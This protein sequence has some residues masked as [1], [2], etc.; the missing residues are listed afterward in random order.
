MNAVN[1]ALSFV[2]AIVLEWLNQG[3]KEQRFDTLV[4][5]ADVSGFTA[6]SEK[7]SKI[8]D[9]GAEILTSILNNYFN[10]M[11]SRID[12]GGGFVGKFGG[13]AMTIFFPKNG[14]SEKEVA[15]RAIKTCLDL[16]SMMN[17]FQ[18]IETKAGTFSLGMKIGISDGSVLFRIVGDDEY[19]KE[20]LFTGTP[21]DDA[22]GAEHQGKSGEVII[23]KQL[24]KFYNGKITPR[25]D[26]FVKL[27]PNPTESGQINTES[28]SQTPFSDRT[29][30]EIESLIAIAKPFLDR[31]IFRRLSLGLDS[32]GEIRRVSVLFM[33]FTGFDYDNDLEVGDK[34]D[35]M[36]NWV[37]SVSSK[38]SGSINKVDMGD[39]GSK[40]IITFGAPTAH[41]FDIQ[42]AVYCGLE[43][44]A[45]QDQLRDWGVSIKMGIATGTVFAGEVGSSMRQEYTVMGPTVNLAAR[46]MAHSTHGKL[47]VEEVTHEST[48]ESFHFS[49]STPVQFKGMATPLPVYETLGVISSAERAIGIEADPLVGR[50]SEI[51]KITDLL[52]AVKSGRLNTLLLRGDA[53]VGKSRLAIETVQLAR[54]GRF[55]IAAG[56][57]LSFGSQTPYLPWISI[58]RKLFDLPAAGGGEL[59]LLRIKE[60]IRKVDPDYSFRLP[61]I[62]GL[63]GIKSPDND[64]TRHFDGQ[65]RQENLFDFLLQYFRSISTDSP[66]VLLFED[67]QW[68]DSSS[69][70]LLAYLKRNLKDCPLMIIMVHRPEE[71][72]IA[73]RFNVLT[74]SGDC[75]LLEVAEFNSDESK[76]LML[77]LLGVESIDDEL[78]KYIHEYTHGNPSFILELINTLSSSNKIRV[79]PS[80]SGLKAAVDGDLSEIDIPDSLTGIIMS[81]LDRLD[82]QSGLTI[83]L[84]AVIGNQF[85]Q[86][87]INES[88][89]I[90]ADEG[91]I[92]NALDQLKQ[93]E[94]IKSG[95]E[96]VLYEYIFKNILTREVAYDS[97]LFAHRREY[98]RRIG[99]CLETLHFTNLKEWSEMLAHHFYHSEDDNRA[100][101]YLGSSGDKSFHI[102]ANDSAEIYYTQAIERCPD[103]EDLEKR[104]ILFSMRSKVY[105]VTGEL[106]LQLKD[107]EQALK[108]AQLANNLQWQIDTLDE[109]IFRSSRVNDLNQMKETVDKATVI[110]EKIDY[111][112]GAVRINSK[113]GRWHFLNND[114]NEA[115]KYWLICAKQAKAIEDSEGLSAALTNIGLAYRTM[116]DVDNALKYYNSSLEI[117]RSNGNKKSEA[118]TLGNIGALYHRQGDPEHALS[119]L[120]QAYELGR[121]IGSK[122]IQRLN[123]GNIATLY[124]RKGE[125]EKSLELQL[126]KLAVEKTMNNQR[127]QV[128]TLSNIGVWYAF[129]GCYDEA[130]DY[131]RLSL[132]I[133][134]ETGLKQ[135]EPRL[136]LNIGQVLHNKGKLDEARAMLEQAILVATDIDHK[137]AEDFAR[138]YLG[139]VL[140]DLKE[141]KLAHKEFTLA[142]DLAISLKDK[143]GIGAAEIGLGAISL[144]E[145][146]KREAIDEGIE[147]ARKTR[148]AETVIQGLVLKARVIAQYEPIQI[149][150][151]AKEMAIQYGRKCDIE[152]IDPLIESLSK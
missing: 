86:E 90:Q 30:E 104:Y 57:A 121:Q 54:K 134:R 125:R 38:Y 6:M 65:L 95:Q 98:H 44:T 127:G 147:K 35:F 16:Q 126:E 31:S 71:D 50:D 19:G 66:I 105:A 69:L 5:F 96:T 32:V 34:L 129:E 111:P 91:I 112:L 15:N 142:L 73:K 64:I 82:A 150:K 55:E 4:A 63:L 59:A 80:K 70:E 11:I 140:F 113:L 76:Q 118:V 149:L 84:A 75:T 103:E 117:D 78:H 106:D 10:T 20:F 72:N 40:M 131:Y 135:E 53:G 48:E 52:T 81:K 27:T 119:T 9:E 21:L 130:L 37:S 123:L 114:Y 138:R 92:N 143:A 46:L 68:I 17:L 116:G 51:K 56:E 58:L 148:D 108:L 29:D 41:E 87:M 24:K 85:S 151:E 25:D 60:I 97:L 144:L 89:P 1:K 47:L 18:D 100:M 136:M 124:M 7:L 28:N 8:G 12:Q 43:L 107:L 133:S 62:A 22:A 122:E 67:V 77:Q 109:M 33:S 137:F 39:K 115:L 14:Q 139:F 74:G 141:Y 145:D 45:G 23:T 3:I 2:P 49:S 42:H 93:M 83:K 99:L 110:L 94:I 61:I 120:L 132:D 102:F 26:G 88:Y 101:Q 152:M 13:D 36:Y 146:G 128:F 79:V